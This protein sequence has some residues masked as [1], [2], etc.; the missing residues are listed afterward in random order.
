MN[1]LLTLLN[2]LQQWKQVFWET[3]MEIKCQTEN[4]HKE[5]N[6]LQISIHTSQ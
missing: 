6:K 5:L 3:L 4:I 2:L 1:I